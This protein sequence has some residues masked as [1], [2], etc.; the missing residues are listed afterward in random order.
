MFPLVAST[1]A[2]TS[3]EIKN[4]VGNHLNNL[5]EKV[6]PEFSQSGHFAIRLV[7]IFLQSLCVS[8]NHRFGLNRARAANRIEHG[9]HIAIKGRR[10]GLK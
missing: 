4:N 10:K 5:Q 2:T 3:E 7:E 9:P 8:K 6:C 1:A